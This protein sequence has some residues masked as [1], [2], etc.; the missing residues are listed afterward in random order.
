MAL[1]NH[2]ALFNQTPSSMIDSH[3][4]MPMDLLSDDRNLYSVMPY[5]T[6][7]ELFDVLEKQNRFTEPEARFWMRQILTVSAF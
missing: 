1:Q 7:G 6:G 2:L 3:I 5:C 4:M